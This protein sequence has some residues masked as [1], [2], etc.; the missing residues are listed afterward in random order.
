MAEELVLHD[1]FRS[2]AS[3]R[4]RI[5]LN[6]KGLP[7]TAAPTSLLAGEQ[8]SEAYRTLNPQGFVPALEAGGAVVTQSFAIIDWLDRTFPQP[9]LIPDEPMPRAIALAQADVVACDIHPLNNLRVLKYL[10]GPLALSEEQ[11]DEWYRHWVA[12]GLEAL[13]ALARPRAGAFL[14]GDR[15]TLADVAA[16]RTQSPGDGLRFHDED[17]LVG[18]Q[19]CRHCLGHLGVAQVEGFAGR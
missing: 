15:P 11:K 13:E 4:V 1:Y 19:P 2:S 8:K 7:Y 10:K 12:E 17:Q 16:R 5:A 3:Y 9:R 18:A 6:L 14:F